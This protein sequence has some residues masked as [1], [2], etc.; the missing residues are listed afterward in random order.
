MMGMRKTLAAM[1]VVMMMAVMVVEEGWG[2]S[3]WVVSGALEVMEVEMT[4]AE[5]VVVNI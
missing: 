5:E 4:L 3:T 2:S 1:L